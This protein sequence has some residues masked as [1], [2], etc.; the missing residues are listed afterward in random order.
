MKIEAAKGV[1]YHGLCSELSSYH[2]TAVEEKDYDIMYSKLSIYGPHLTSR[3]PY[4][5]LGL[6]L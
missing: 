4:L 3:D 2:L 5:S 1:L 6:P